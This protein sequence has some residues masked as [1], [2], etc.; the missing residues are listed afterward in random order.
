MGAGRTE[1]AMSVFGRSYGKKGGGT[2]FKDGK[3]DP[4]PHR[5]RRRSRTASPMPPRIASITGLNLMD[6]IARSVTLASLPKVSRATV[7]N[8]HEEDR[9]R[10]ALPQ[11][12]AHQGPVGTGHHRAICRAAISRRWC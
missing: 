10:R 1:L 2:V 11:G 8:E 9:R 5:L 3:R 4:H 6:N 7:I 12:H